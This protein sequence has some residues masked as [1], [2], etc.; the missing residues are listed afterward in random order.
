VRKRG[1]RLIWA[2]GTYGGQSYRQLCNGI[3]TLKVNT[4]DD[5]LFVT[6]LFVPESSPSGPSRMGTVG[7]VMVVARR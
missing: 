2:F 7:V 5:P 3:L 4:D 1:V 6:S